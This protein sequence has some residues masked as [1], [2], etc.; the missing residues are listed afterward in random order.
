M[1]RFRLFGIVGVLCLTIL[2]SISG[3]GYSQAPTP[4]VQLNTDPPLQS[5]IP[6]EAATEKPQSPVSLTF[7][8]LDAQ[9]QPFKNAKIGLEILTPPSTPWWTTDFPIVEGTKLLAM[10]ATAPQGRL[11]IQQMLPIRGNY[12]L[13]VNVSPLLAGAFTPYEQTLTLPVRENPVK[14]HYLGGLV[15]VLL[16]VGLLGGVV[17]GGQ[18]IVQEGEIAPQRVRL[19][20]SGLIVVAIAALLA[21]NI[22][23]ELVDAHGHSHEHEHTHATQSPVQQSQGLELRLVGDDLATV[24]QPANFAVS[25]K[26]TTTG[27]PVK[28]VLFQVKAIALEDN[29][30][31]FAYQGIPDP[32]GKLAWQEQFFDGAPHKVEVKATPQPG[33]TRQFSPLQVAREIEV[34][35]IA[36]PLFVR[37]ISLAYFTAIVGIGLVIGLGLKNRWFQRL[38]RG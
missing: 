27:Q 30:T 20:L 34:E 36:P 32:S 24:G 17:I 9:R 8:A 10:E 19:L 14:Y 38:V 21:I 23:A 12:Q 2:I 11:E 4:S 18:Q 16:G 26:D 15:I 28:D 25:L 37:L 31:V 6:F 3:E 7:Q 5:L 1:A 13:R 22:S 29:L 33:S 35:G